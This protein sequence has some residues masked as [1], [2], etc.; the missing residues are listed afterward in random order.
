MFSYFLFIHILPH[1]CVVCDAK[2]HLYS[3]MNMGSQPQASAWPNLQFLAREVNLFTEMS[4]DLNLYLAVRWRVSCHFLLFFV[5]LC[6]DKYFEIIHGNFKGT[7]DYSIVLQK[8]CILDYF[9]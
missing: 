3:H 8:Y 4:S 2:R 1:V 7:L 5:C 9:A 6:S